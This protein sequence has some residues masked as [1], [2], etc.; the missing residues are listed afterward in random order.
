MSNSQNSP[1]Y[2][3]RTNIN[4]ADRLIANATGNVAAGS[5]SNT[6][7]VAGP[8][9]S[10]QGDIGNSSQQMMSP[11]P[12]PLKNLAIGGYAILLAVQIFYLILLVIAII[13]GV[14]TISIF[15][16]GTGIDSPVQNIW[17]YLF[18]FMIPLIWMM[19]GAMVSVGATL[20]IYVPMIPYIIFTVGAI[21]WL[22]STI[23]AMVAGPLVALGILMPSHHDAIMGEAK[24]ALMLLFNIFLRPSLMIFGL[25]AA[26]LLSSMVINMVNTGFATV[27]ANLFNF[28]GTPGGGVAAAAANPLALVFILVAYVSL[29]ITS[30]NKCFDAIHM[31][32]EKVMRWIGGQ[33]GESY[34]ED[35]AVGKMEGA[36]GGASTK[37]GQGAEGSI[38]GLGKGKIDQ[39][40]AKKPSNTTSKGE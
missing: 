9:A 5:N 20:A 27:F 4:A 21:G 16:L 6:A 34:G 17:T 36:V 15:V 8:A 28:T 30:L 1:I 35:A 32:P 40:N 19:L 7:P 33:G 18:Y 38:K 12:N 31:V 26:I 39:A 10:T 24:P 14:S 11:D 37:A 2:H 23:E 22:F 29:V 3:Y 13:A 25:V